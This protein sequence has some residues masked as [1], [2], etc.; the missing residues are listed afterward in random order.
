MIKYAIKNFPG[1]F[2]ALMKMSLSKNHIEF[3]IR[4]LFVFFLKL[5]NTSPG[6]TGTVRPENIHHYAS[7]SITIITYFPLCSLATPRL[8]RL[9]LQT[10]RKSAKRRKSCRTTGYIN[11][12]E[13]G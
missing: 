5:V 6:Q 12:A 1:N 13:N 11:T 2:A 10:R 3:S 7:T 8:L 4:T 9:L